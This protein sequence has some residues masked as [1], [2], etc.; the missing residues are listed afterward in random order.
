MVLGP[1]QAAR[2]SRWFKPLFLFTVSWCQAAMMPG[3][4]L[5]QDGEEEVE[6]GPALA[7]QVAA[8]RPQRRSSRTPV[9]AFHL[10][11]EAKRAV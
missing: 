2:E 8:Q 10:H 5:I 1:I 3:M 11:S 7:L 4:H 9:N 6:D